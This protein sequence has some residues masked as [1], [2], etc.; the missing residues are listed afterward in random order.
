MSQR[1]N[2]A[3]REC[4]AAGHINDRY[5]HRRRPRG[6]RAPTASR[7]PSSWPQACP[8]ASLYSATNV[9][10]GT[11]KVR[12]RNPR[13]TPDPPAP[14]SRHHEHHARRWPRE[15]ILFYLA[16]KYG[17]DIVVNREYAT[18]ATTTDPS[19]RQGPPRPTPTCSGRLLTT[20]PFEPYVYKSYYFGEL[21][22]GPHRRMVHQD[23]SGRPHHGATVG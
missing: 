2:T 15:G 13:R 5:N 18:R 12:G 10:L 16:D 8:P 1:A 20:N 23:G 21:R 7:A 9:L 4:K 22:R 11:L 3:T 14:R 6:T 19:T 17:V